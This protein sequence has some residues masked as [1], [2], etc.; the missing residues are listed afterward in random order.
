MTQLIPNGSF[1]SYIAQDDFPSWT[2]FK[3]T[4]ND[5]GT[6]YTQSSTTGVTEGLYSCFGYMGFADVYSGTQ[7]SY[8]HQTIDLTGIVSIKFDCETSTITS[9]QGKVS[10]YID[11][12]EEWTTTTSD[13][14]YTNVEIDT[15]GYSGTHNVRLYHSCWGAV[16]KYASAYWDNIRTVAYL[17]GQ[18]NTSNASVQ[19]TVINTKTS[20]ARLVLPDIANENYSNARISV[21]SLGTNTSDA[22]IALTHQNTNNSNAKLILERQGINTG[23]SR[24]LL[25]RGASDWLFQT[26]HSVDSDTLFLAHCEDDTSTPAVTDSSGNTTNM[27]IQNANTDAVSVPGKFN[28]G[29]ETTSNQIYEAGTNAFLDGIISAFNSKI[30]IEFWAKNNSTDW[31]VFGNQRLITFQHKSLDNSLLIRYNSTQANFDLDTNW[32]GIFKSISIPAVEV[33]DVVDTDTWHHYSIV[34]DHGSGLMRLLIDG[35]QR[36]GTA[37]VA[38][39]FMDTTSGYG[40][41]YFGST[42]PWN[43]YMDEIAI[44]AIVRYPSNNSLSDSRIQIRYFSTNNSNAKLILERQG[45]KT[46]NARLLVDDDREY[47]YGDARI[48]VEGITETTNGIARVVIINSNTNN[49][50]AYLVFRYQNANTSNAAIEKTISNTNS[51]NSR[52]ESILS[53]TNNSTAKLILERQGLNNSDARIVISTISNSSANSRIEFTQT[54]TIP[55]NSRIVI[56]TSTPNSSDARLLK[57]YQQSNTGESRILIEAYQQTKQSTARVVHQYSDTNNSN[58][59]VQAKVSVT[60]PSNARLETQDTAN[61]NYSNA[62]IEIN[63][64]I[65]NNSDSRITIQSM[66][67]N[68]SDSRIT[69]Q[70]LQTNTGNSRLNRILTD[71]SSS[72]ARITL[73]SSELLTGTARIKIEYSQTNSTDARIIIGYQYTQTGNGRIALRLIETNV[74]NARLIDVRQSVNDSTA[75]LFL[76]ASAIG[77]TAPLVESHG[78]APNVS[79]IANSEAMYLEVK[80]IIG[81]N[82][83]NARLI[84]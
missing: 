16:L 18:T 3:S 20:N 81:F 54:D 36:G 57:N 60:K 47:N 56:N 70:N 66:Q 8:I 52:I 30:T 22:M 26:Q 38:A 43:G 65:T 28:L 55:S 77:G 78:D 44:S 61:E 31:S 15:T 62:R 71:N 19:V 5:T 39:E 74:S 40:Q 10:V 27:V 45:T 1:E 34:I 79:F 25:T 80:Q 23:N 14:I 33:T 2:V 7:V 49:S 84:I 29:F 37:N 63:Y 58:A 64:S 68:N 35:S 73:Q 21:P 12:V 9:G 32:N 11:T 72:D 6:N 82:Y 59:S 4:E 50:N 13:T 75:R 42:I 41:L 17:A 83:S 51:S 24:I 53:N 46:S 48:L 67:T 76:S 69:I